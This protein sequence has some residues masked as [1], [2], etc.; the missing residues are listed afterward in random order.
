MSDYAT[1]HP[2]N[3][4]EI[5][6]H[7]LYA[8]AHM[9]DD[10]TSPVLEFFFDVGSPYSYLAATQV[11][12][13]GTFSGT[14]VR[15]R[16]FLLGGV[17]KASGNEMPARVPAKAKYMLS[18]LNRWAHRYGVE[19]KFPDVFPINSLTAQ[20]VLVAAHEENPKHVEPLAL[21]LFRAYWV[22]GGDLSK[23]DV[24]REVIGQSGMDADRLLELASIDRV[25]D[26]LRTWTDEAVERGAFGS[27][28]F[29]IGG[30][31]YWGND[32]LSFVEA[33]IRRRAGASS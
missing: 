1:V 8:L 22:E 29:F 32:R 14:E 21:A 28:T 3:P 33:E 26:L 27:P 20:R 30:Q 31:M 16:P 2:E 11:H 9:S 15:W 6:V 23:V 19:F 7:W 13:L 10:A 18:D 17:F 25:K 12:D 4:A 24:I 5:W